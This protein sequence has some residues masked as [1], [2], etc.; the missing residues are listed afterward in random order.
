[1]NTRESRFKRL[2]KLGPSAHRQSSASDCTAMA[3]PDG[4]DNMSPRHGLGWA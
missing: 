1:M 4:A 3:M 2:D